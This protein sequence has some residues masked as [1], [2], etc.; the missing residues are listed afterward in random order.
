M[1]KVDFE[2]LDSL[3]DLSILDDEPVVLTKSHASPASGNKKKSKNA[4][5]PITP[6][7]PTAPTS[8]KRE[9]RDNINPDLDD[10]VWDDDTPIAPETPVQNKLSETDKKL[11]ERYRDL[12]V[13]DEEEN[14][15]MES[16]RE[17]RRKL[18]EKLEQDSAFRAKYIE[19][20]KERRES[21]KVE[22]H[23]GALDIISRLQGKDRESQ[24]ED[25]EVGESDLEEELGELHDIPEH[26]PKSTPPK[27]GKNRKTIKPGVYV[28]NVQHL[29]IN[30]N[31][32]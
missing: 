17:D 28:K 4:S 26:K 10:L 19:K 8:E 20:E 7:A 12:D 15:E 5:A 25:L 27:K 29:T 30:I 21:Q 3:D 6:A 18:S 24:L 11:L 14:K 31:I 2:E 13:D 1:S 32:S 22:S 23:D 16:L 9:E